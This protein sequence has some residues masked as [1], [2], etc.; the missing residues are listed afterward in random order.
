MD[1]TSLPTLLAVLDSFTWTDLPLGDLLTIAA[2]AFHLDP[3]GVG[4]QVLPGTITTR[5]GASVV[6]LS[7]GAEDLFRD[8]DDGILTPAE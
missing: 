1:I 8:L 4:N 3:A 5:N 7:D 6:V 2:G